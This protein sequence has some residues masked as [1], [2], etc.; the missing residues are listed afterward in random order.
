MKEWTV[1]TK[2]EVDVVVR[3]ETKEEAIKKVEDA[4]AGLLENNKALH[5]HEDL[6]SSDIYSI[7]LVWIG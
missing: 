4:N 5:Q 2:I 7:D 1:G 3:A 6:I